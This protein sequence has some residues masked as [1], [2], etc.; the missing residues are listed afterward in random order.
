[1][2]DSCFL[3]S[4]RNNKENINILSIGN[5]NKGKDFS[6]LIK[7]FC[8]AFSK[9]EKVCLRIGGG[10][11]EEASL[12]ALI[13]ENERVENEVNALTSGNIDEFLRLVSKSGDSSYKYLQ[14]IYSTKDTANQGI[15]LGLMMSE[16][17][18]GDNG[19]YSNSVYSNG[20][21]SDC[22]Y[23]N[24]V[25]R[26]HGGGFAGTILAIVKDN[27]VDEYRRNMDK[28]FGDGASMILQIRHCGGVRII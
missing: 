16:I 2:V 1:M 15:S 9:E 8:V 24:G 26:V 10:G 21:Y 13:E 25:C 18:L 5:L 11:P 7:A 4:P 3:Y 14:N 27:A 22:A 6:T 19:A 20:S 17:F 12:K 28:I 23:S